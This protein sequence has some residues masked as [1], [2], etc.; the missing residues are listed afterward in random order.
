MI[1]KVLRWLWQRFRPA[2]GRAIFLLLLCAAVSAALGAMAANWVIGDE[3]FLH[4]ALLATLVGRK[5]GRTRMKGWVGAV[6]LALG[7]VAYVGW[8]VTRLTFPLWAMLS[9]AWQR[10]SVLLETWLREAQAR[11]AMLAGELATWAGSWFGRA[12]TPGPAVSLFWMALILWAGAAFAGW[13]VSRGRHSLVSFLPLGGALTLSVYLADAGKGEIMLFMACAAMITPLI[14]LR[15]ELQRWDAR[16]VPYPEVL[17]FDT[18]TAAAIAATVFLASATILPEV[19][20]SA[21]VDWFWRLAQG[22]QQASEEVLSRAFLGARQPRARQGLPG[23][24]GAVLPREH[25]LGGSPDLQRDVVMQVITDDPPP[26]PEEVGPGVARPQQTFYWRGTVYSE[27][28]GAGWMRG[29]TKVTPQPAYAAVEPSGHLSRRPLRQEFKLLVHHGETLYAAGDPNSVNRAV[30]VRRQRDS[31]DLVAVE[32]PADQYQVLSLVP[33]VTEQQLA[34]ATAEY[35]QTLA[36]VYRSLPDNLPQRIVDLAREVAAE[37]D[38]PY[39]RALALEAYLRTIPYDLQVAKP[40]EGRDVVEYFL[41]DLQRGYCDYFASAMVVMARAVDIPARLAVGYAMGHHDAV[42]GAYV[43]MAL[44]AHAWPELYFPGYGWIPFEPTPA[45]S[46]LERARATDEQVHFTPALPSLPQRS[47]WVRFQVEA[48][49]AWL[50]WQRWVLAGIVALALAV[51]GQWLW[52]ALLIGWSVE[53]RVAWSYA[54]LTGMAPRLGVAVHPSDT[55][56]EFAMAMRR[57]L[58][59]RRSRWARLAKVVQQEVV[60]ILA[61]VSLVTQVYE[62]L[63]YAA[64]PPDSA[65][66]GQAWRKGRHLRWRLW[67][68]L[69]FSNDQ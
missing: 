48:R 59:G 26:L 56:A 40:P 29:R 27:Y 24:V 22:P 21:V 44:D 60:Q 36:W 31:D 45:Y 18:L 52:R 15:R 47:W 6:L 5:L 3:L 63:S 10:D 14:T 20:V 9:A 61:G 37:A 17:P 23:G 50:R 41:F 7:G 66:M 62:R 16:Q 12:G 65:L 19:R 67:R 68:L 58:V 69:V 2:E 25:L 43:V 35:P 8:W 49:L 53:E 28:V 55:P 11:V 1:V 30:M 4:T 42:E 57:G 34:E 46:P 54:T 51:A 64:T 33:D 39:Q 13:S 32:S 38:T